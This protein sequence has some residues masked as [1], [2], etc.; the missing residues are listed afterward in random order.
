MDKNNY[1][2]TPNPFAENSEKKS[3]EYGLQ[4][5]KFIEK[6]WIGNG[7]FGKRNT[8]LKNLE[9]FK[10]NDVDVD[11]YKHM[12]GMCDD[13]LWTGM[14]WEFTPIAPK[15]TNVIK[16]GFATDLFKIQTKAV[17]SMSQKERA[18]Y[19]KELEDS[20]YT[21]DFMQ[22]IS[23]A[24]DINYVP[25]Y[26]PESEEEINIHMQ[27][28]YRQPREI[29]SELIIDKV[30][31]Y[32]DW[33]ETKNRIIED[34]IVGR[35]GVAKI[36]PDKDYGVVTERVVPSSF[37]YSYDTKS[38]RNKKGCY[39][40]GEVKYHTPNEILRMSNG[41]ITADDLIKSR[42]VKKGYNDTLP[43]NNLIQ[44]LYFCFKTT[45]DETYKRKKNNLIEK[46]R[47]FKLPEESKSRV[48]RGKYDV[49][50]EGYYITGTDLIWGY[51]IMKDMIRPTHDVNKVLPPYVAYEISVPSVIEN[52]RPFCEDAH[53]AILKLR[54]LIINMQP[55]GFKIDIDAISRIDIGSGILEPAEVI[56][57]YNQTGKLLYSGRGFDDDTQ[58]A[59]PIL[60]EINNS[61]GTDLAQLIETY[62]T[63]VNMCY[64]VSGLNRVRDGSAPLSNSLVG[65]QQIALSMSNTATKHILN[66]MLDIEKGVGEVILNRSQQMTMY[67]DTFA[68]EIME[69]F[70]GK[71]N[72]IKEEFLSSHKYRFDVFVEVAPDNNE[73]QAFE[74]NLNYALQ[75]GQIQLSDAIELRFIK[76]L[77]LAAEYLKLLI[78]KRQKEKE[79]YE[80]QLVREKEM[81]RAQAEI[82]I[83]QSKIQEAQAQ[84]QIAQIKSSLALKEI[85][86]KV[87]KETEGKLILMRQEHLYRMEEKGLEVRAA[88]E[89]NKFKEDAKDNRTKI[90]ADQQS[91]MIFQRQNGTPPENFMQQ[92]NIPQL[93][94]QLEQTQE[95]DVNNMYGNEVFNEAG[96]LN[97]NSNG[98]QE[99][100][101][102]SAM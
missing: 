44:V 5:A 26:T 96:Q 35:I 85:N 63:A 92:D 94:P 89:L 16:D 2:K 90:Q 100:T 81:A 48:V 93:T 45:I 4:Y 38:T 37:I 19:R 43:D 39:Y 65:T 10:N 69:S 30:L 66:A 99:T 88:T 9:K 84:M 49:W 95:M 1:Y 15:F 86:V 22:Q 79:L 102:Q 50:F 21:S 64:E 67:K 51:R 77:K 40:F 54:Q 74:L 7:K 53:I 20:M 32:N 24:T 68:D 76:N 14:N 36:I 41:E 55:K 13:T 72:K 71:D 83:N 28:K 18:K 11:K 3:K 80:R 29:A 97:Q 91:R 8:K 17:D 42:G 52:I 75:A 59:S 98:T 87:E 82:A 33:N 56:K 62:N 34:I 47:G 58:N 25:E 6:E 60:T 73:K 31:E 70:I 12:L 57:I 23:G 61:V 27:L 101:L 46:E 78:K